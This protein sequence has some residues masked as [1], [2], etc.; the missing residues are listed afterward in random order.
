MAGGTD[1]DFAEL[2]RSRPAP[3]ELDALTFAI[4][5]RVHSSDDRSIMENVTAQGTTVAT[6]R[7]FADGRAICVS[8]VTLA[9]R[10]NPVAKG[11]AP[12]TPAGELPSAV[13]HRQMSLLGAAWT[14]GSIASLAAAGADSVTWYETV[15]WRGLIERE[16][17]SP[18][19]ES[20]PCPPRG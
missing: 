7:S 5:P 8:P 15:G 13:D 17:G 6:A 18:V 14:V 2:N 9:A 16:S 11:P 19:P 3:D 10:F 4:D 1:G 20:I 12:P